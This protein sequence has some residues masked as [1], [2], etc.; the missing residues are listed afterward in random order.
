MQ[1]QKRLEN[2]LRSK[3]NYTF[4]LDPYPKGIGDF[5]SIIKILAIKKNDKR[6]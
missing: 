5:R 3:D 4:A 2:I 1:V 6:N